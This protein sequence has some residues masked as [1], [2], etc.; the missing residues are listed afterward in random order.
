MKIIFATHNK[1]KLIE[2]KKILHDFEVI[3]AEEAGVFEDVIEDGATFAE[4]ALKKARF[5]MEKTKMITVADDSGVCIKALNG[6]PG[7][8]SARWAGDLD[9]ADFALEKIKD[10]PDGQRQ[11]WFETAAALVFPDGREF[12]F[13]GRMHGNITHEKRGESL[14]NLPY[15]SIL[16]PDGHTLTC[17]EMGNEEKNKISH[18]GQA[19]LELREFLLKEMRV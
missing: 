14:P 16:I 13:D 17:A 1:G 5:V 8:F 9:I 7:V 10:V 4:N 2:M 18:R 15:D 19:F 12:V 11:A 3:G 6:A